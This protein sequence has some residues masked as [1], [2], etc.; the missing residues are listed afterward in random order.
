VCVCVGFASVRR[1]EVPIHNG[2]SAVA[3]GRNHVPI[4]SRRRNQSRSSITSLRFFQILAGIFWREIDGLWWIESMSHA[5]CVCRFGHG[6]RAQSGG[7]D[8]ESVQAPECAP[9]YPC[10]TEGVCVDACVCVLEHVC[11]YKKRVC[12]NMRTTCIHALCVC[13]GAVGYGLV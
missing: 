11:A 3:P 1:R 6:V 10:Y 4:Q 13:V 9:V 12:E 5:L 8:L 2:V 7:H